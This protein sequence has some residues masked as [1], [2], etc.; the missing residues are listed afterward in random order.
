M[1]LVCLRQRD[2]KSLV[3]YSSVVHIGGCIIGLFIC[4]LSGFKGCVYI[5]IAHGLCSSGLF[6]IVNSIY[7]RSLSRSLFISKGLLN[8]LPRFRLGMFLLL[9]ANIA[10]PPTINLVGEL[11]LII[12]IVG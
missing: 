12:C 7:E 5:M 3:A 9:R 1:S 10:A 11:S 2:I 8:I 6:F 4:S